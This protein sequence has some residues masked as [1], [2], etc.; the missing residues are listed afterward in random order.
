LRKFFISYA[1][2][3]SLAVTAPALAE[4]VPTAFLQNQKPDA[5]APTVNRATQTE[6]PFQRWDGVPAY[7]LR[8]NGGLING[9]LPTN[10]D[11]QG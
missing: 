5:N 3:A 8:K 11:A 6:V 1:V 4:E 7:L 2:M 9:L 10:P